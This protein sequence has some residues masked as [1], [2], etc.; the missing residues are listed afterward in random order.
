M[1]ELIFFLLLGVGW[2]APAA[3]P[4]RLA[5]APRGRRRLWAWTTPSLLL[6]AIVG[7]YGM[8][9]ARPEEAMAAGLAPLGASLP[10]RLLM[11]LVPALFAATLLAA[12]AWER[13][14]APAWRMIGALG[15]ATLV[16]VAWAGERLATVAHAPE[17]VEGEPA[18][19]LALRVACRVLLALGA[20][21][22]LA[23]G[24]PVWAPAAGLAL[25]LYLWFLPPEV[26]LPLWQHGGAP[27]LAAATAVLLAARWL[28]A[29]LRRAA[30][31]AGALLIA[32]F[33]VEASR[34][35]QA[36]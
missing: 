16:A 9:A 33:F 18:W 5:G 7:A 22:L 19:I 1:P 12:Y 27:T 28:P 2:G 10:G 32:A 26:R 29:A 35:L 23:P 36:M 4:W 6:A 15:L 3:A 31:G 30:L 21:E 34:T 14:G 20:G 8:L 17:G 11:P 25:P 24:R 13:L